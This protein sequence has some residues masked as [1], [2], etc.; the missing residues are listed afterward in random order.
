L[1]FLGILTQWNTIC[2]TS[3]FINVHVDEYADK[4]HDIV[5]TCSFLAKLPA[6]LDRLYL[7]FNIIDYS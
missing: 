4:L 5:H 7:I 6:Q 1:G 3:V 2:Y